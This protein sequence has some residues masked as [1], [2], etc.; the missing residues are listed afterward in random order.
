MLRK[1]ALLTLGMAVVALAQKQPLTFRGKVQQINAASGRITVAGE[2]VE[3]WMAAMTM[4]YPVADK[5]ILATLK[6]GDAITA[7]VY[8]G[9]MALHHVTIVKAQDAPGAFSLETLEQLALKNNP[10]AAQ[11]QANLRAATAL[12]KQAGLYPNP[13]VGYYG[14]EIRGGYS[15]GGKQGAFVNQTIVMGG[16]LQAA[17]KVATLQAAE[18]ET[19]AELQRVRILNSV[20][21]SFYRVL[22]AQRLVAVRRKLEQLAHETATTAGHLANV[23]QADK[24]DVLQAEVEQEQA[25]IGVKI[26]EQTL[27]A[28][29]RVLAAVAGQPDLPVAKLEGDLD[30][31]PQFT[32]DEALAL[33]LRD[34]PEVKLSQVA[35][36]RAEASLTA[37][38]KVPIPDLQITGVIA[39]NFTPLETTHLPAGVQGAAQV[40]VQLPLFNRNQGNIAA[41][42]DGI[43]SSRQD[44]ERVRL[45][46]RR[47]LAA[48]FRDY[49]AARTIALQY[50]N[51]M[52]PR[53]EQAYHLYQASYR[54]MAAAYPQ[55][56]MSQRTLFQLEVEYVQALEN[57]WQS[58]L[59]IRGFGLMDGLAAPA[60]S[61]AP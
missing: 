59:A 34:S 51:Q 15:G 56:Q 47:N 58:A 24:P 1:I 27:T 61:L 29:W 14:D 30:A 20:R 16:K 48:T 60:R 13:T 25:A 6:P 19:S 7:T 45:Q 39:N 31:V 32:F 21:T 49:D 8:A 37:A 5:E 18:T 11:A 2:A 26:A 12:A 43:E 53:A 9:D 52:L 23:G 40:G 35:V 28:A 36:A 57:A 44:A 50:K 41:A 10:T 55:V 54:K 33:T 38:K 22:A 17:R 42:K 46:L 4:A 3:G